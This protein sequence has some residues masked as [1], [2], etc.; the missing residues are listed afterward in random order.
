[1]M[2]AGAR[3]TEPEHLV[4]GQISKAHGTKGE[5]VIW[6]LTDQ[7]DAVFTPGAQLLLGD[8]DGRLREGDT[9]EALTVVETRP[10]KKAVLVQFEGFETREDLED[11]LGLYV[12]VPIGSL[13]PLAEGEVFYHQLLG[14]SVETVDGENIGSVSEVFDTEPTHL[15]EVRGEDGKNRLIPFAAHI[16]KQVDVAGGRIVI[17]PPAGLLE[18]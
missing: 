6:P 5:A 9:H 7:P 2:D 3:P 11:Y 14:L 12:L 1:M 8:E 15:L 4:V 18:I 17:D 13:A 10:F 16:V